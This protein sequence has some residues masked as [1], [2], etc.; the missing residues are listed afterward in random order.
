MFTFT[1]AHVLQIGDISPPPPRQ[2]P[3]T[4]LPLVNPRTFPLPDNSPRG[5]IFL[6]LLL[7]FVTNE[8][9]HVCSVWKIYGKSCVF[10]PVLY[11]EF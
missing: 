6:P 9:T 10:R 2:S 5:R 3:R 4:I 7:M 1:I 11:G 8:K